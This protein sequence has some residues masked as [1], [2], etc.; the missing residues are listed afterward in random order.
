MK[1]TGAFLAVLLIGSFN[2]AAYEALPANTLSDWMEN[3]PPFNFILI[4]VRDVSELTSI[5]ANDS[6]RPY[7]L[8][9]NQG[10][11]EDNLSLL[12][13][14]VATVV[15]CRSGARGSAA[16]AMLDGAGYQCDC[17][18]NLEGGI[19]GWSGPTM[20]SESI[21]PLSDLP[22]PSMYM[23]ASSIIRQ[24]HALFPGDLVIYHDPAASAPVFKMSKGLINERHQ[25]NIYNVYG[26]L[27]KQVQNPF[28]RKLSILPDLEKPG[29]YFISLSREHLRT[30]LRAVFLPSR[31]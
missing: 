2:L 17:I 29:C 11:F 19:T 9:W 21:K 28:S 4:D 18:Y 13:M 7:H 3:G 25:L 24:Q 23:S 22:G 12:P 15:Y 26:Q 27:I 8:S 10:D 30:E 31:D 1:K 14:D 6:C 16:A 5:I 20:G